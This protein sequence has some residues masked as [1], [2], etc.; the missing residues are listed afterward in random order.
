MPHDANTSDRVELNR[1]A[2]LLE[3]AGKMPA[4]TVV[5]AGGD[6]TEDLRLV[7]SARD[8]GIIDRIVLIGHG[9]RIARG[10][11]EVGIEIDA[12]DVVALDDQQDV[13]AAT[14]ALVKAGTVDV[15]LKGNISTPII[16]RQMMPLAIRPTVSLATVFDAAMI[17]DGRMTVLTDA[18]VTTNCNVQRMADLV[19]NAVEVAHTV[20]RIERPRVAILSAN[21]KQIPALPSTQMGA[22]LTAMDW[23]DAVVYGPLS[24]DLATDPRSVAI[25]GLPDQPGAAEVAGQADVLVCPGIDAANVLYKAISAAN[26]YGLA[27][28]ASIT[29]GF[30]VPY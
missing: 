28:L 11:E 5:V 15:V 22:E 21:E 23:P 16:N 12:G 14:A 26:K 13:A 4:S 2:D 30:P 3:V 10:V 8:H 17:G 29:I 19:R 20:L 6:R 18:G 9:D 24:L 7:E 27:S 1:V 25:K